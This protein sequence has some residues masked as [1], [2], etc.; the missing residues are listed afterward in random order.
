[1]D[2]IFRSAIF[3]ACR[4]HGGQP[5]FARVCGVD[6]SVIANLLARDDYQLESA[7]VRKLLEQ[8]KNQYFPEG[9]NKE[10]WQNEY[11]ARLLFSAASDD[12]VQTFTTVLDETEDMFI[13][14]F[15]SLA[16][17][18]KNKVLKCLLDQT[19][20]QLAVN[21]ADLEIATRM[22]IVSELDD[23]HFG[24]DQS[25]SGESSEEQDA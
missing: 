21:Y 5:G 15:R 7:I 24:F 14:Y 6:S 10:R 8:M 22:S 4:A 2:S 17:I 12:E 13:K 19:R 11:E 18:R 23:S 9:W 20:E 1:M 16:D 3:Q 25:S